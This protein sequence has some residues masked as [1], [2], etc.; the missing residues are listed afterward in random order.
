MR[1]I[2]ITV[3]SVIQITVAIDASIAT[4]YIVSFY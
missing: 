1:V 4:V 3:A 2:Q